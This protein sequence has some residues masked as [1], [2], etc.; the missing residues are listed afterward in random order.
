[1]VAETQSKRRAAPESSRNRKLEIPDV[2][3]ARH[4]GVAVAT[5]LDFPL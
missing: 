5:C 3:L 4:L 1:M 2:Q